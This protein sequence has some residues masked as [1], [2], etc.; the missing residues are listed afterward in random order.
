[1]SDLNDYAL[2]LI[3][4]ERYAREIHD[5]C[6]EHMYM[7]ARELTMKLTVESRILQHTLQIMAEEVQRRSDA[8]TEAIK[9]QQ[10]QISGSSSAP[11]ARQRDNGRDGSS[12]K[13]H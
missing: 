3:N 2:P 6:L 1:M 7:E 9:N 11:R 4:I 13:A 10:T 8:Y 5:L 12:A